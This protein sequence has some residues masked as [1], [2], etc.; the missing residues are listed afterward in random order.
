MDWVRATLTTGVQFFFLL[1]P[2]FV[3]TVFLSLTAGRGLAERRRIARRTTA[4]M[5]IIGL[6]LYFV[7]TPLLAV[8]GITIDAFRIGAGAL[9]FLSAVSLVQDR[10]APETPEDAGEIAVVPLA[11]PVAIGP[12]T[13]GTLLV[14][15]AE[16]G[17]VADMSS[18]CAGL[19]VAT[20]GV[21]LLL[22]GA[23]SVER[24]LGREGVTILSKLTG[25]VLAAM[26]AQMIFTGVRHFLIP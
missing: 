17:S 9:L 25:L 20:L 19:L 3:L 5:A 8:F 22:Y 11:I 2:F 16:E 1:T 21:G 26:A 4:A 12:A 13:T 6:V 15:G 18:G 10:P 24:L 14:M 7:G 23:A